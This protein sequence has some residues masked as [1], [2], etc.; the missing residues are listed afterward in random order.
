MGLD[1]GEENGHGFFDDFTQPDPRLGGLALQYYPRSGRFPLPASD[2]L[3]I[4]TLGLEHSDRLLRRGG[5]PL[6]SEIH[7]NRGRD[8][9]QIIAGLLGIKQPDVSK[10]MRG[11]FRPFSIERL[12]RFLVALDQDVEIV[13]TPLRGRNK[14]AALHVL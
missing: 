8:H 11:D 1:G 6:P 4:D 12:L 10:M 14:V 5:P 7:V 9:Q 3:T 13:V 2:H